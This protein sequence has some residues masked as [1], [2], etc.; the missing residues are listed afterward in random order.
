M[1][2]VYATF[3]V[4]SYDSEIRTEKTIDVYADMVKC[5]VLSVLCKAIVSCRQY[6]KELPGKQYFVCQ[7][8]LFMFQQK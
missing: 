4:V 8:V 5:V 1:I 7:V 3:V 6:K 2:D